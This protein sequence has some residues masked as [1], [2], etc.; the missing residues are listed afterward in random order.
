MCTGLTPLDQRTANVFTTMCYHLS[1]T[2]I[3]RLDS[4]AQRPASAPVEPEPE[5]RQLEATKEP[6]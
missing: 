4:F 3:G 6:Q 5:P 1:L 2:H